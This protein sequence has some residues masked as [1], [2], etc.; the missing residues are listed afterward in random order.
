[1]EQ[2]RIDNLTFTYPLC[3]RPAL[4]NVSLT[5]RRGEYIVLCG[6]SGCGK[7]TLLRQLKPS[8]CPHG[9]KSGS[10][11]VCGKAADE[12]DLRTETETVGFVR[13]DPENAVATDKVFHELA[14]GLENL[15]LDAAEMRLRVAE[16]AACFGMEPTFTQPTDTLSGGQLQMLSLASVLVMH[17]QI[18]L[19]DEPTAQ[20]DPVSAAEFLSV[21]DRLHRELGLTILLTEHRLET[22]LPAADRVIVLQDGAVA[23]DCAVRDIGSDLLRRLPALRDNLP[24]AMRVA[25]AVQPDAETL[26][27]T[28]C[29]G[30]QWLTDAVPSPQIIRRSATTPAF[31]QETAI[32]LRDV[33]F[34]YEKGGTDLLRGLSLDVPRGSVFALLGGNGAGKSTAL[35]LAA[36]LLRPR[37]GKIELAGRDVRRIPEKERY[38]HFAAVLPQQVQTLFCGKTVREDLQSSGDPMWQDTAQ[39]LRLTALLHQHPFDLSGGEQQRLALGKVLLTDPQILFLDEPTKG[40]DGA[41]KAD[42]ACLLRELRDA[43]KT[44]L[45]V[46]HDVEFCARH[47]DLC[48]M[49][50]DGVIASLA[51]AAPF[52][53]RNLFYTTAASRMARHLFPDAVTDEEVIALCRDNMR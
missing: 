21:V 50:F 43:G 15:G 42:F 4:Q 33:V 37:Q 35:L 53:A 38:R 46:S 7:T 29:E 1:M 9:E 45:L 13:Q 49:L 32:K 28:V 47:A 26:P 14:F 6:E 12:M 23:A 11:T 17:P 10:V 3:A 51:P 41:F 27:I 48:A 31:S 44:V 25:A 18:L 34:A 36:G 19:L 2:I 52:F 5:I 20:L 40:M 30:K 22:V 16:M 24:C 8:V 39:R